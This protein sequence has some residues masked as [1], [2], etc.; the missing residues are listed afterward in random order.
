MNIDTNLADILGTREDYTPTPGVSS[1]AM[2]RKPMDTGKGQGKGEGEEP[3][4]DPSWAESFPR[5]KELGRVGR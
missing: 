5:E 4:L 3:E 2:W 1:T